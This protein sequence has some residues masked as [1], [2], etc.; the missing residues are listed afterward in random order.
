M[1]TF[2]IS[3]LRILDLSLNWHYNFFDDYWQSNKIRAYQSFSLWGKIAKVDKKE[4]FYFDIQK[5]NQFHNYFI[6]FCC[7]QFMLKIESSQS[8]RFFLQCIGMILK[9]KSRS[10]QLHIST[11]FLIETIK[12]GQDFYDYLS[13]LLI[14]N[15]WWSQENEI[16][17]IIV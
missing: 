13:S 8:L 11:K 10:F 12:I 5:L 1:Q 3:K 6:A 9:K 4:L 2:F 15:Y 14:N 16:N 7:G 17:I